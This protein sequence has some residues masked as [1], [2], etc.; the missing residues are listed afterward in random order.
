MA[1]HWKTIDSAPLDGTEVE[2]YGRDGNSFAMY[3]SGSWFDQHAYTVNTPTH[4][5]EVTKPTG[6]DEILADLSPSP[7]H[8]KL[9]WYEKLQKKLILIEN[10]E[11]DFKQYQK[12][13]M[14]AIFEL[15]TEL[16]L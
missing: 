2:L 4:W 3:E 7:L 11:L 6:V 13:V 5:R 15:K 8:L 1:K 9:N 10:G 14:N 12:D 16:K